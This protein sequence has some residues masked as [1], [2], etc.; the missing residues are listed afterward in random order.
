MDVEDQVTELEPRPLPRI[1][2]E[3]RSREI[4]RQVDNMYSNEEGI[5]QN[6]LKEI[7]VRTLKELAGQTNIPAQVR[8]DAAIQLLH[9][10]EK[11]E[12]DS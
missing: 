4:D 7:A 12:K 11:Q 1:F 5:M 2:S 10:A 8:L 6:E 3:E 9:L